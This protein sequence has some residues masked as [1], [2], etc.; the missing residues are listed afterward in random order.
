MLRTVTSTDGTFTPLIVRLFRRGS[1]PRICTYLPSPSSRSRETLGRRPTASAT[2]VLGR[3]V[4]TPA[5]S[6]C[7]ILGDIR[8]TLTASACPCRRLAVTMTVSFSDPILSAALTFVVPSGLTLTVV[9]YGVK[10]TYE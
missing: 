4:I 1:V 8:S 10:P 2:F 6:T 9:V 5:G 3:L 7:T